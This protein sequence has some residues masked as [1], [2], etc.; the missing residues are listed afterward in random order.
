MSRTVISMPS[1]LE[2]LSL[3]AQL[4]LD[5]LPLRGAALMAGLTGYGVSLALLIRST[6]GADPWDVLHVALADRLGVSVGTVI[7]AV[8]FL[9]L[10]AWIPLRQHPGIGTLA[11]AL[12]VGVA[13]D[14]TLRL[15]PEA[16]GLGAAVAMMLGA[17]VLNGVSDAVYIGAQLGP[18][19]RD[20][21]M[22]GLHLRYGMPIGPVRFGIEAAVLLVGWLLGGPVGIGT[23]LYALAIGPIV[24]LVLPRVTLRVRRGAG[25]ADAVA[26]VEEGEVRGSAA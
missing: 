2:N 15:V 24:H 26:P 13:A 10:L 11:N 21:L 8:S 17:I 6:L 22:T 16:A 18:G 7:I 9:V 3:R 19:P 23:F 4:R 5:R 12:W 20:G 14:I 1:S 25:A